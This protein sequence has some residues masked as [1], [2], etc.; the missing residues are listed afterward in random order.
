MR[1]AVTAELAAEEEDRFAG[2]KPRDAVRRRRSWQCDTSATASRESAISPTH[3]SSSS[4]A[5]GAASD[6]ATL[7]AKHTAMRTTDTARIARH[8]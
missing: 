6:V 5:N 1:S 3:A 2:G 7:R 8:A 4:A